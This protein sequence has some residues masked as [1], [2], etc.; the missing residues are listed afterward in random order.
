MRRSDCSSDVCSSDH[1][2]EVYHAA[3]WLNPIPKAHWGYSESNRL[4]RE[5]MDERMYPLP[6]DGLDEAMRE[7]T[8]KHQNSAIQAG[9]GVVQIPT[10]ARRQAATN[11]YTPR[12]VHSFRERHQY[13]TP[14]T[15][16]N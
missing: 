2:T 1:L 13:P 16:A 15:T 14:H 9:D 3:V 7:L 4:I 10:L 11:T 6:L 5:L 12:R 8:R